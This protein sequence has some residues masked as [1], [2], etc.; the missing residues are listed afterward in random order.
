MTQE[1]LAAA[2]VGVQEDIK[3][4]GLAYVTQLT[5]DVCA[6]WGAAPPPPHENEG[7]VSDI[8]ALVLAGTFDPI[9]PP[10]YSRLVAQTLSRSSFFELPDEGHGIIGPAAQRR[11]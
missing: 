8:P 4:A 11:S 6:F 5:L 1:V 9:T 2:T 7:V 10:S 3:R